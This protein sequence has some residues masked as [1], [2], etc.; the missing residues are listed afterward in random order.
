V[1]EKP[2][3][4]PEEMRKRLGTQWTRSGLIAR[5][6]HLRGEEKLRHARLLDIREEE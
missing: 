2:G 3:Q 1:Q 6:K 5:V 4:P